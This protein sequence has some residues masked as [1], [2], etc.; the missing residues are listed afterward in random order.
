VVG[1]TQTTNNAE[2]FTKVADFSARGPQDY[3]DPVHGV[4]PGVRAPVDLVA[5]GT[6]I[7]A[8]FYGG[9]SGGNGPTLPNPDPADPS[10][11]LY[12]YPLA[13]TSFAAPIV[14]GAVSLLDSTSKAIEGGYTF[15]GIAVASFPATSRDSRIIKAILMN[16]ADKLD[17]WDN[18]QHFD[19]AKGH[20]VTTQSLDWAQGAGQVNF[21][22]AFLHY[23]DPTGTHDI[24][25]DGG[26]TVSPVGFDL[27]ALSLGGHNDYVI[28]TILGANSTLDVTLTWFRDRDV[29][30]ETQTGTDDGMANLDLQIWDSSFANLLASS[31]SLYNSSEL[32]HFTLPTDGGYGIRVLYT[33]QLFGT[34]QLE[35]YGLAWNTLVPEP[36]AFAI[37]AMALITLTITSRVR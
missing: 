21:T 5:P 2:D 15:N 29:N 1:A 23:V 10:T 12:S 14:S 37:V 17:G 6:T 36:S 11:D 16:S 13:G 7:V 3:S 4:V 30:D 9:A 28:N 34:P 35:T 26:G 31:E 24:D 33:D 8:A 32:L 27:G 19:A 20:V 25:G 18:G 22:R